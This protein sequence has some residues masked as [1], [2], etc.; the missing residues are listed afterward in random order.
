MRAALRLFRGDVRVV[1]NTLEPPTCR[2]SDD[3]V[4]L[5]T[6]RACE[7]GAIVTRDQDLLIAFASIHVFE[8]A[9]AADVAGERVATIKPGKGEEDVTSGLRQR[10]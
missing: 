10:K 9:R 2:D 3:D 5:A 1:P 8:V 4:V 6:A 7:C